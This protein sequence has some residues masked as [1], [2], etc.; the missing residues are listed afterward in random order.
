MV[1]GATHPAFTAFAGL[2]LLRGPS[3]MTRKAAIA[4]AV[5]AIAV[6]AYLLR[7]VTTGSTVRNTG[8]Q[9]DA[10]SAAATGEV[11]RNHGSSVSQATATATRRSGPPDAPGVTPLLTPAPTGQ[12]GLVEVRVVSEGKAV[13]RA[14]VRL[15]WRGERDHAT[16]QVAWRVAGSAET[17][18][19]GVA[20]IAAGP[21]GGY[22]VAARA[23]PRGIARQEVRRPGGE[24]V[25]HVTLTLRP[26]V[27]FSGRTLEK[28]SGNPVAM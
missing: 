28:G 6:I 19:D 16:A 24:R 11:R 7:P 27:T 15:Y 23:G 25:T 1:T 17:A 14:A 13:S 18:A 2:R 4:A 5:V 22:L 26:A 12:D 21:P 9:T 8:R 10:A 20:R 3:R